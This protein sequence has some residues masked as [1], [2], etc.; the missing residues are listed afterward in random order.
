M[1]V[2]PVTVVECVINKVAPSHTEVVFA[3]TE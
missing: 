1:F 3:Y 2:I